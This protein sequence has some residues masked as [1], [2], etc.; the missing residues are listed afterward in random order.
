VNG[1]RPVPDAP[2]A[3]AVDTPS[4]ELP[5]A[6]GDVRPALNPAQLAFLALIAAL[7]LTA[8][9]RLRREREV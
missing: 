1:R 7:I 5:D 3:E 2:V 6:H 4:G 8:L 9:R